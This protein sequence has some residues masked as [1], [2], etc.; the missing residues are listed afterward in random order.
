MDNSVRIHAFF[1]VH[2]FQTLVVLDPPP[3][4]QV[5][6]VLVHGRLWVVPLVCLGPEMA[7]LTHRALE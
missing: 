6:V 7:P 4:L 2:C 3:S 1:L 5:P